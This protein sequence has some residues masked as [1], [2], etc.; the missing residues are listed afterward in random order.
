M[1]Y[2]LKLSGVLFLLIFSANHLYSQSDLMHS[3]ALYVDAIINYEGKIKV[4]NTLLNI[5]EV[6]AYTKSYVRNQ[7][8]MK[9]DH[10]VY[11]VYGDENLELGEIMNLEQEL[12]KAYAGKRARYLLDTRAIILDT[13][14]MWEKLK[15]LEIKSLKD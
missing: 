10:V 13:P 12:Q 11:R 8:V 2:I 15:L 7:P 1:K 3:K 9:Y 14:N 5:E 6:E 4:H